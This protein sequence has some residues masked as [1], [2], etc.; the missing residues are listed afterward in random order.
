MAE[1]KRTKLEEKDIQSS[2]ESYIS[3]KRNNDFVR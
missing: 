3:L 2:Q 1:S